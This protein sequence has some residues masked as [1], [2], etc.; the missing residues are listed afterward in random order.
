[1]APVA[2]RILSILI[3]TGKKGMTFEELVENL[4]ASKSTIS[5]HL[6]NLQQIDRVMYFTK[7]GDRKKYFIM[8]PGAMIQSLDK[9]IENWERERNLHI[10][11]MDYKEEINATLE[12]GDRSRFELEFHKEY[13]NF[14]KQVCTSME[15]IRKKLIGKEQLD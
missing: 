4:S 8:K 2:A 10:E 13:I 6:N 14:F 3:L 7:S 15:K 12:V 11:I 1:M 5:T 9:M